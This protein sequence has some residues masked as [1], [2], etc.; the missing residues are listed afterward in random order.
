MYI[1]IYARVCVF[2]L[3]STGIQIYVYISHATWHG[4]KKGGLFLDKKI[5][6]V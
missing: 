4:P 5:R 3:Y 1:Y 6:L 2:L